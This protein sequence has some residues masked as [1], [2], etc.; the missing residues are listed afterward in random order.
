MTTFISTFVSSKL[1]PPGSIST[2][3]SIP[4]TGFI[5][6]GFS[7]NGGITDLI[8]K[9]LDAAKKSIEVQ[10]YSFT[11]APIAA[12]LVGANRRGVMVR[13]ILD[14][15]QQTEKYSSATYLTNAG[16]PVHIDRA[17]AIAHNKIMIVDRADV[18]TGSFNFTKAA[19]QNNA[20]NCL[21]LRGNQQ[22]V[23]IYVMNWEW[24]WN[25]T[26]SYSR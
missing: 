20:E 9:E 19:E 23:D 10:A 8:I 12:A 5:E 17:F 22:L 21:I 18:I 7:P 14:K 16:V 11:S 26:E 3:Q 13:V 24:R 4:A 6:V 2:P 15:S 25:E 1:S